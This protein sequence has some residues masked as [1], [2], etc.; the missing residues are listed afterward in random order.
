MRG[1]AGSAIAG[2]VGEVINPDGVANQIEG[3]AIQAM[4]WTLKEAV[5]FDSARV[6]SD[7]WD[8][9]PVL[10]FS[11]VPAVEVGIVDSDGPAARRRRMRRSGRPSPR[12]PMPWPDALGLRV[13]AL[14]ITAERI[15]QM[16]A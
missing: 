11:E 13:R 2:D 7:S 10:R 9:Y 4:Q 16:L 12:S 8:S 3:G 15:R 5:R 1:A 6:T 14:P